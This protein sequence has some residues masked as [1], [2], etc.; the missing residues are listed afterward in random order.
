MADVPLT[1]DRI[2][3]LELP[4]V[5]LAVLST[6]ESGIQG[7]SLPEEKFS[8]ANGLVE[9]GVCGVIASLWQVDDRSTVDADE[10]VNPSAWQRWS[11][12][13]STWQIQSR[14]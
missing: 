13:R 1:L 6:C 10:R 9:A 14:A 2:L 7:V 8:L 3:Q 12:P 5:R 11:V 4:H